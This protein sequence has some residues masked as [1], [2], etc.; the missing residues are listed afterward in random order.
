MMTGPAWNQ[1]LHGSLDAEPSELAAEL[2]AVVGQIDV[3][4]LVAGKSEVAMLD[5]LS[6]SVDAAMWWQAP[7]AV[8]QALGH[9]EVA[10]VLLP[11]AHAVTRAAT[12]GW[13]PGG[14]DLGTQQYVEPIG[15]SGEGPVLSGA[16]DQLAAWLAGELAAERSAAERLPDPAANYSGHW[17]SGP[18]RAELV[19]TSRAL[20]GLGAVKLA[21]MEDSPGWTEVRC[22]PVTPR[23]LPRI[24][25][26]ASPQD[27]TAL[28]ARYPLDVTGSR[29]HDWWRVSGWS[30][31]WLMPN[32]AAAAADYD[33]IHLTVGSYLT[34]AGSA[35]PVDDARTL[36]AGWNPDETYWLT[37]ILAVTGQPT[38]W[39]H[40][41]WTQIDWHAA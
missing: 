13:W 15:E 25:E 33:A 26:I 36:L 11:V 34:T 35:L 30:G 10:D 28:A 1:P 8:D 2:A 39:V 14:A 7:D 6:E 20:P 22:W 21:A 23:Q 9:A 27:W 17:W 16:A 18:S 32:Y 38:R 40:H 5:P 31:T 3:D 19:S 12:A 29:R 24:Y 37:D 4:A 41:G